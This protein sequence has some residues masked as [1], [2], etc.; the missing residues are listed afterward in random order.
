MVTAQTMMRSV[1]EAQ[2]TEPRSM[3]E[4]VAQSSLT[5]PS[6]SESGISHPE[7]LKLGKTR[8]VKIQPTMISLPTGVEV[9]DIGPIE[10]D[11]ACI[12]L[13]PLNLIQR[14]VAV[15]LQEREQATYQVNEELQKIAIELRQ[16]A[17]TLTSQAE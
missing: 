6:R 5:T 1:F 17:C 16:E 4:K 14:E 15:E 13:K 9:A 2:F 12:P 10:I 7:T 8:I 3:V 11:L